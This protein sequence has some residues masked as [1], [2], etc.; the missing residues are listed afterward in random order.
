LGCAGQF[1]EKSQ[2]AVRACRNAGENS[3]L[4]FKAFVFGLFPVQDHVRQQIA[5]SLT[6]LYTGK[7][8]AIL[9]AS[10]F[11]TGALWL[12]QGTIEILI[13]DMIGFAE[14]GYVFEIRQTK[15]LLWFHIFLEML[16]E[17]FRIFISLLRP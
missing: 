14:I 9:Q 1:N 11:N 13:Y 10:L 4:F 8:S 17:I 12:G 3:R 16:Q 2:Q 5:Q 6:P 15:L 7:K